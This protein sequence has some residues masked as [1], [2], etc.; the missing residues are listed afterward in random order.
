VK[1]GDLVKVYD[2]SRKA[3]EWYIEQGE[4]PQSVNRYFVGI[5]TANDQRA[6]YDREWYVLLSGG[7]QAGE[8][9]IVDE[10]RLEKV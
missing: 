9:I 10:N 2:F 8:Q 7:C 3:R 6:V 4:D 1:V 5:I